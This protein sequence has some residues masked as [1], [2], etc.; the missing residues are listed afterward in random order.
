[1]GGLRWRGRRKTAPAVSLVKEKEEARAQGAA[2]KTERSSRENHNSKPPPLWAGAEEVR[3]IAEDALV[4]AAR[5]FDDASSSWSS[6]G[7]EDGVHLSSLPRPNSR[8][9]IVRGLLEVAADEAPCMNDLAQVMLSYYCRRLWDPHF[10]KSTLLGG[11]GGSTGLV[12]N[13]YND[14]GVDGH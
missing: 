12:C 7:N 6:L 8:L 14:N 1:M 2:T 13:V 9:P 11:C 10:D 5:Y 3:E 4:E